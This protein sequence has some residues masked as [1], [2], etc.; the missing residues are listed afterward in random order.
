MSSSTKRST[1]RS[2]YMTTALEC[3]HFA[4]LPL[5]A[6]CTPQPKPDVVG[7]EYQQY[8]TCS[9]ISLVVCA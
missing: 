3:T 8:G 1:R 7:Y 9:H 5:N 2:P 6:S 4:L